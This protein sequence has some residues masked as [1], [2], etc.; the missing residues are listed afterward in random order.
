LTARAGYIVAIVAQPSPAFLRG[1]RRCGR[2]RRAE[3][4]R[5]NT[6]RLAAGRPL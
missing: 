6:F 4:V 5:R 1:H 2:R 3:R